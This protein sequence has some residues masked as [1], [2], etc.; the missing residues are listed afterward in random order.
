MG[1]MCFDALCKTCLRVYNYF[2]LS[3][4]VCEYI[5]FINLKSNIKVHPLIVG[6]NSQKHK[7]EWDNKHNYTTILTA[8]SNI[9]EK[10]YFGANLAIL[11]ETR[12]PI[13]AC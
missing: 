11:L 10:L 4:N 9:T 7:K 6:Y 5:K 2:K 1:C 13:A 12:Q 3:N 8:I